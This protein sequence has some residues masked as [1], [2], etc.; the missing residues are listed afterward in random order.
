[1]ALNSKCYHVPVSPGQQMCD[2]LDTL[3]W[4]RLLVELQARRNVELED[5]VASLQ[6]QVAEG[7]LPN[8]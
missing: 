4:T 5:M 2:C 1:M 8:G 7:S 3:I 6:R